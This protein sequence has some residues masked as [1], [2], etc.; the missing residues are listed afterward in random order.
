MSG[1]TIEGFPFVM[2]TNRYYLSAFDRL[3]SGM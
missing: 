2:F 1:F 3:K